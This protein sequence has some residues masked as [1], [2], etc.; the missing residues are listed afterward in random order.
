VNGMPSL[1]GAAAVV[2]YSRPECHLCDLA[3]E[4]LE[5]MRR[6]GWSFEL[7]E[8]D[9]EA[10]P[11]LHAAYLERIPVVEVDGEVVSELWLDRDALAAKLDTVPAMG[12]RRSSET[13]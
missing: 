8:L 2:L 12:S 13:E 4:E 3:R 10:E 7:H 1:D 9:I 5:A 11:R 6:A